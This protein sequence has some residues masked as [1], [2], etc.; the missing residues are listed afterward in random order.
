MGIVILSAGLTLLLIP[1]TLAAA[2]TDKWNNA[3]LIAMLVIGGVCLVRFLYSHH[4]R[5]VLKPDL[6]YIPIP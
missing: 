6:G 1:L 4:I 3:S 2:A 5:F